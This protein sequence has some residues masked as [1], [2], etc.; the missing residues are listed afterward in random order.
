MFRYGK[1]YS[2]MVKTYYFNLSLFYSSSM[3]YP[4]YNLLEVDYKNAYIFNQTHQRN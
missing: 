2:K 4:S 3:I 1:E